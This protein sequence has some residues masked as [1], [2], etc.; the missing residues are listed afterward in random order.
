MK[1]QEQKTYNYL[2]DLRNKLAESSKV[3]LKEMRNKHR[4]NAAISKVLQ[5]E[6]VIQ[7][8]KRSFY[9]YVGAEPSEQMAKDI[10]KK[11]CQ[12][13]TSK[14]KAGKE[15]SKPIKLNKSQIQPKITKETLE[16]SILWG[17]YK[18]TKNK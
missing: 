5:A 17:L 15:Y 3:S 9:I 10:Y 13:S 18:Y 8:I 2:L 4:V 7:K 1:P 12:Y 11:C 16:I 14:Y 6:G